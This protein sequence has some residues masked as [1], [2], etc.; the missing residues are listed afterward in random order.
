MGT[1][2]MEYMPAAIDGLLMPVVRDGRGLVDLGAL[3]DQDQRLTGLEARSR[4]P[5]LYVDFDYGTCSYGQLPL[6]L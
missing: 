3:N 2:G 5:D 1:T 6:M 4:G